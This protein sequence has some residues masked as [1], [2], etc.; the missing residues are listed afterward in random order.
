[1]C[2][3]VCVCVCVCCSM[4][5]FSE[6][7][8]GNV[9]LTHEEMENLASSTKAVSAI[10]VLPSPPSHTHTHTL[11]H[12]VPAAPHIC[13][14]PHPPC[15]QLSLLHANNLPCLC[16]GETMSLVCVCCVV[17]CLCVC[18]SGC[19]CVCVCLAVCLCVRMCLAVWLCMCVNMVCNAIMIV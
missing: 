16:V 17:L 14:L 18:V 5:S 4:L 7:S 12:P 1:M 11:T 3:F 10:W 9:W 2:V 6:Q 15:H 13:P 8:S 19:L